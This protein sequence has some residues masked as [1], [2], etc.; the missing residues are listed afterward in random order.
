MS[1]IVKE[2]ANFSPYSVVTPFRYYKHEIR[3][4]DYFKYRNI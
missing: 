2:Y 1:K 3:V 4:K